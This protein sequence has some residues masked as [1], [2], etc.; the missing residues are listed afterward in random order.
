MDKSVDS[1]DGRALRLVDV[2]VN[3]GQTQAVDHVRL[4]ISAGETIA[5]LGPSGCGKSTLL[6][7]VAGLNRE[8]SGQVVHRGRDLRGVPPHRR[9]FAMVFQDG[10]LF[11]HLTVAR[12]VAYGLAGSLPEQGRLSRAAKAARVAEL[13]DLVG[14]PGLEARRPA[15]LSGGERQRVALARALAP[16]PAVLLLDEPLSALDRSLRERLSVDLRA[17][18]D[19]TGTTA[20]LVTHDHGEARTIGHR[21]AVMRD[22]RVV[23]VGT[24]DEV[25]GAPVDAET[26][27]FLGVAAPGRR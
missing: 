20:I 11:E 14:L 17:I 25:W 1:E 16:R 13:L 6:R 26:A 2:S 9:R 19:R 7:V 3:F 23:Q 27:R 10:Q 8:F 12:N 4:D 5:V 15:T 22:G 24:P 18:L 21:V